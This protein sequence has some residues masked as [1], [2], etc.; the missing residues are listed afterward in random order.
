MSH[1]RKLSLEWCFVVAVAAAIILAAAGGT[2]IYSL[3]HRPV[4]ALHPPVAESVAAPT[5]A[6]PEVSRPMTTDTPG[7][8]AT[9]DGT[10]GGQI[11][12]R[13]VSYT[14]LGR[15]ACSRCVGEHGLDALP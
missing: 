2:T 3:V 14:A 13:S 6:A 1:A 5:L 7:C 15:V 8:G 11:A 10:T 4:A 12:C 9:A